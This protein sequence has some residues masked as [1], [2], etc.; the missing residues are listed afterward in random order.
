MMRGKRWVE[1]EEIELVKNVISG[2]GL[3]AIAEKHMRS[4]LSITS[5][6]GKLYLMG[7]M[8]PTTLQQ[9]D[10]GFWEDTFWEENKPSHLSATAPEFTIGISEMEEKGNNE[11]TYSGLKNEVRILRQEINSLKRLTIKQVQYK[12]PFDE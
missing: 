7:S 1:A 3:T 10:S 9:I 4:E 11:N 5:R 6:I 12:N 2:L 8:P